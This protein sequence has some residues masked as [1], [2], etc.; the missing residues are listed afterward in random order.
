MRCPIS[1][2]LLGF[3][4]IKGSKLE[5]DFGKLFI[6][7]AC[8]KDH[9]AVLVTVFIQDTELLTELLTN[10]TNGQLRWIDTFCNQVQDGR[11]KVWLLERIFEINKTVLQIE[12]A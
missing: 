8:D 1:G 12:G 3:R 10:Y 11:E 7:Q 9:D 4:I 6:A 5:S 2:I